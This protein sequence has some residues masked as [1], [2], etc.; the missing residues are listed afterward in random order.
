[1]FDLLNRVVLIG[2]WMFVLVFIWVF[3]NAILFPSDFSIARHAVENGD[4]EELKLVIAKIDV[5][6]RIKDANPYKNNSTLLIVAARN[7]DLEIV[8][9]LIEHGA[10]PSLQNSQNE[11][12]LHNAIGCGLGSQA[13]V[14]VVEKLAESD[15]IL[16]VPEINGWTPLHLCALHSLDKEGRILISRGARLNVVD[17]EGRTPLKISQLKGDT[18]F[19]ELLQ[20]KR[21]DTGATEPI[22]SDSTR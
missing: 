9:L 16:D 21:R 22:N 15:E 5:D 3:C 4:V 10:N 17:Q 14:N 1:M 11:T 8:N 6:R 19:A 7:T 2:I 18:Q 20:E 12:A 13:G